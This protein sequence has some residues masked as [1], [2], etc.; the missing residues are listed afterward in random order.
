MALPLRKLYEALVP[1]EKRLA[2]YKW[3]HPNEIKE[4]RQKI[5]PSPKGDFSLRPY[6]EHRAI[7]IH[8]TKTA[9]TSVAKSLFGYLPYHYTAIDYRIFYGKETFENYF[10]FAFV[11]NPWDRLYSAFR[12]I[13]A[14]GWNERDKAWSAAHL[15]TYDD[16]N[17]FVMEWLTEENIKKHIHFKPQCEFVCDRHGKLLLDYVAYFETLDS[18]F[19]KIATHL[20]IQTAL[21]AHNRNPGKNYIE[22]YSQAAKSKVEEVYA[23]DIA[24]FGYE[25]NG[26]KTR[27]IANSDNK[28]ISSI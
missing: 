13:K 2:F 8:I 3:R 18:D 14:G 20:N 5:N 11:R 7:F 4:L 24:L 26:I 21:G 27:C 16:F 10:K 23:R 12:Y 19:N 17:Q 28:L 6:D 1:Y 9:G 25:F 22:V 15:A